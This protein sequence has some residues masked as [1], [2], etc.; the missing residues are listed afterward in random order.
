[1]NSPLLGL[2]IGLKRTGVALSD[3]GIV[4]H[5][6]TVIEAKPPHINNVIQEICA[7]LREHE[8]RTLV[9]GLPYTSDDATTTQAL[10]VEEIITQLEEGIARLPQ[11]PE[12]VRVNEFHSSVDAKALYPHDPLDSAS[13]AVILQSYLDEHSL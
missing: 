2:D 12:L 10:R 8:V 7:L 3:S 9:V 1:M 13:A 5:P 4:A 11:P 6:L